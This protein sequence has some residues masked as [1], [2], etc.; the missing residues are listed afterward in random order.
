MLYKWNCILDIKKHSII[1]KVSCVYLY[2]HLIRIIYVV[3]TCAMHLVN[4]ASIAASRPALDG[5][6]VSGPVVG[7]PIPD[8]DATI[9][10]R[11]LHLGQQ[12]VV[13]VFEVD[14][15]G[16][17]RVVRHAAL[18][19]GEPHVKLALGVPRRP[20]APLVHD[21]GHVAVLVRALVGVAVEADVDA[22][23]QPRPQR[24]RHG[25]VGRERAPRRRRQPYVLRRGVVVHAVEVVET[26]RELVVVVARCAVVVDVEVD[27]VDRRVTEGAGHVAV[28]AAEERVPQVVRDGLRGRGGRDGVVVSPAA[29]GEEDRDAQ[30]LAVLDVGADA[31]QRVAGEVE[32][33]AAVAEHAVEGDDDGVVEPGVAGLTQCALLLVPA[34]E[35]GELAC[36]LGHGRVGE[37]GQE[38]H[39]GQHEDTP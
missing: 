25:V 27:A 30:G 32:G 26:A 15:N 31:V 35:D 19:R 2:L 22:L 18:G 12:I 20:L 11:L 5:A 33:V 23:E 21:A 6:A 7:E 38:E 10:G 3:Y 39:G 14:L 16:G 8:H 34:P 1:T 9:V 28:A 36:S 13:E 17:R 4:T 24:P 37:A 29:D